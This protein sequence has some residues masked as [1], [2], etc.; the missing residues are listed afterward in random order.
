MYVYVDSYKVARDQSIL[1]FS[2]ICL[3]DN[4]YFWP[5]MLKIL[6]KVSIFLSY[7]YSYLLDSDI[8][9]IIYLNYINYAHHGE[10]YVARLIMS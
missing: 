4:S 7:I 6:L 3:S 10:L 8:I 2:L 9:H 5:I 1:L